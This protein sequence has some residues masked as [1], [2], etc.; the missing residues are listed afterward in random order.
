MARKKRIEAGPP[1]APETILA[2]LTPEE[3][4][5]FEELR[6][7]L[8]LAEV[9]MNEAMSGSPMSM[10]LRHD[11]NG[12]KTEVGK[13][14]EFLSDILAGYPKPGLAHRTTPIDD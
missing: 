14:R 8:A 2:R 10:E 7:R 3:R 9:D 1:A 5:W 11:I 4:A 12:W 13:C 6:L